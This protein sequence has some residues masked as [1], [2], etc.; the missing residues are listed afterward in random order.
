MLQS[1]RKAG[2]ISRT[3]GRIEAALIE[4]VQKREFTEI[5]VT[6]LCQKAG[7]GRQT[8]YRHYADKEDVIRSRIKSVFK[9]YLIHLQ[10]QGEKAFDVD[11]VNLAT[12]RFWKSNAEI[13][14]LVT[15]QPVR[16]IIFSE[17]DRRMERLIEA[18]LAHS[19][20]DPFMQAFRFWG[21]KGVLLVWAENEMKQS[22]E[23][24]NAVLKSAN[25]SAEW[26]S[27]RLATA[28]S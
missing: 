4:L 17:L 3:R 20:L 13:F 21:M 8:F 2:Q 24:I 19:N 5:S 16:A 22:P 23:E 18:N 27:L 10:N 25:G 14:S 12:L 6:R 11:Y 26:L 1:S 28:A 7:V 15:I 9:E